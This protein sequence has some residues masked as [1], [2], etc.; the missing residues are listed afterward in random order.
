MRDALQA[1]LP[2][3]PVG[4]GGLKLQSSVG[5]AVS[6][7]IAAVPSAASG[8]ASSKADDEPA[9]GATEGSRHDPTLI[10]PP[11]DPKITPFQ[12]EIPA[13]GVAFQTD[14]RPSTPPLSPASSASAR[15]RRGRVMAA[16]GSVAVAAGVV[17]AL[18]MSGPNAS[19]APTSELSP[20]PAA[21]PHEDPPAPVPRAAEEPRPPESPP[22]ER[23]APPQVERA[24]RSET[25]A[26]ASA[27]AA[28][29]RNKA[30]AAPHTPP[31]PP[32][33]PKVKSVT[34]VDSAGF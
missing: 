21:A 4:A 30:P 7:G 20:P 9:S 14:A 18:S 32:E 1:L 2:K 27:A 11:S 13:A 24:P 10:A 29:S 22:V 15:S 19:T 5:M 33:A 31:A 23:P 25:H 26:N 8:V 3:L 34:R 16:I 12:N 6:P 28:S 17:I